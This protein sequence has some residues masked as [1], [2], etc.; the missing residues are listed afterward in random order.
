LITQLV[1]IS[2]GRAAELGGFLYAAVDRLV[3]SLRIRQA[4]DEFYSLQ[5]PE[6]VVAF[7]N[8]AQGFN[9]YAA[10]YPDEFSRVFDLVLPVS[11]I[12][13]FRAHLRVLYTFGF[14]GSSSYTL[15]F[16]KEFGEN[17]LKDSRAKEGV[18]YAVD[19]DLDALS[20]FPTQLNSAIVVV[21][22]GFSSFSSF[23]AVS[24]IFPRMS[25]T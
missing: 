18:T 24:L 7:D 15:D 2:S 8:F 12:D 25:A 10:Q 22:D 19:E 17:P 11:G 6:S 14:S 16:V 5:D 3:Y 20:V 13:I 21:L 4:S 1:F 23:T 9:D